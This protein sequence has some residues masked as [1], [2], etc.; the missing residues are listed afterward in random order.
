MSLPIGGGL[1]PELFKAKHTPPDY[2]R[3]AKHR[4]DIR[5]ENHTQLDGAVIASD[6]DNLKL[7]TGT[8]G[9]SD[10]AGK[11]KEHGYYLN[12]GGSV[13]L[14]GGGAT[15]DPSQA[16]KGVA[17]LNY[18]DVYAG[19]DVFLYVLDA[20]HGRFE[21]VNKKTGK[22]L[23]EIDFELTQRSGPDSSGSHDLKVK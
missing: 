13:G 18:R 14:A 12:V 20:Q 15:Q 16:G 19:S 8:L 17:R 7:D 11:D 5:T 3:L 9:Y 4:L 22:H 6:S 2:R 23:G 10:I 21:K 1:A